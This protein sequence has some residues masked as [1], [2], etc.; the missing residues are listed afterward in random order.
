MHQGRVTEFRLSG[1]L[2]FTLISLQE[3]QRWGRWFSAL[4]AQRNHGA[5][6]EWTCTWLPPE[7]IKSGS[8]VVVPGH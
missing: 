1:I 6:F 3:D 4:A 2:G 7:P 8:M 5:T